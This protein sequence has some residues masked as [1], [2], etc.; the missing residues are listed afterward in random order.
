[1]DPGG[2]VWG[3]GLGGSVRSN[4]RCD[5]EDVGVGR[6]FI[7]LLGCAV[8]SAWLRCVSSPLELVFRRLRGDGLELLRD[9]SLPGLGEAS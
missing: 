8:R 7:V 3:G 1:M 2:G 9:L 6:G 5:S 4:L